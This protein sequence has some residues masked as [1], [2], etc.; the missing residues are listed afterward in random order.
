MKRL[1]LLRHTTSERNHPAREDHSRPLSPL[2]RDEAPLIGSFLAAEAL[3]PDLVLCSTARRT[4]DS[5]SLINSR[6][7]AAPPAD[8]DET[9]YSASAAALFGLIRQTPPDAR[10]VMILGHNPSIGEIAAHLTGPGSSP[11]AVK[12]LLLD[13]PPGGLAHLEFDVTR[14]SEIAVGQGRLRHF[15]TPRDLPLQSVPG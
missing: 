7:T 15:V 14:W 12:S 10:S 4:R 1:L 11:D 13:Y 2:G 3:T 8:F 9:I 6:L 5:L